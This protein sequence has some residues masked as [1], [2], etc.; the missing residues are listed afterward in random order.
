MPDMVSA[1][2]TNRSLLDLIDMKIVQNFNKYISRLLL[3][4]G[5]IIANTAFAGALTFTGT[6]NGTCTSDPGLE[7]PFRVSVTGTYTIDNI[8]VANANGVWIDVFS[9][10]ARTGSQLMYQYVNSGSPSPPGAATLAAN[11]TYYLCAYSPTAPV[12]GGTV[13][14]TFAIDMAGPGDIFIFTPSA[15]VQ[16]IPTLSEWGQILLFLLMATAVGWNLRRRS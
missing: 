7:I 4:V 8:S 11:T 13:N 15:E 1:A 10:A 14:T 12:W 3:F 6:L 16:S 2:V 9:G 5:A